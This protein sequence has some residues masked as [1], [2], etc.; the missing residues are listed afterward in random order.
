M[1]TVSEGTMSNGANVHMIGENTPLIDV[2]RE[3]DSNNLQIALIERDGRLV[4]TVTDGDIRRGILHGHA[5]DTPISKVMNASPLTAPADITNDDAR[6]MMQ[7]HSIEQLPLI[8]GDNE[9]CGV[10]L[11]S[12]L[13]HT[14]QLD[15]WVVLMAG[16]LGSRLSPL[17]NDLPKPL[18]KIGGRPILETILR[19]FIAA[20]FSRFFIS[21]NF[22]ADLIEQYFADG[23]QWGVDIRYLREKER[24][25]TAGALGLL[26]E[27]PDKP[28]FVMNGDL[29]TTINFRQMLRYH[30]EHGAPAT[31]AVREHTTTIP[32]GVVE[33]DGHVLTGIQE[34]PTRTCFVNAGVYIL[35]REAFECISPHQ[36]LDM[37]S[38]FS[39]ILAA[40]DKPAVFPIREYWIDVGHLDDLQKA[41]DEFERVFG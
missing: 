2:I 6:D 9:V 23:S 19:S 17:T 36:P 12:E 30:A 39:R 21:V 15:N 22:K 41:S 16:G 1:V 3:I 40:G 24:L 31:I 5:L 28:V 8:N 10:K 37:P 18:I 29:L 34:K 32:F 25:D 4:G 20:G 33:S 11:L 35:G 7:R 13:L 27:P 14:R 26:P 38:L